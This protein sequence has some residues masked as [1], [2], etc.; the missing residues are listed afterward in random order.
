MIVFDDFRWLSRTSPWMDPP[1]KSAPCAN[2]LKPSHYGGHPIS[3]TMTPTASCYSFTKESL[4]LAKD[5]VNALE[6]PVGSVEMYPNCNFLATPC[7][8][9]WVIERLV[10]RILSNQT[11]PT[12]SCRH[13]LHRFLLSCSS[14]PKL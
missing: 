3:P 4:R 11:I 10:T 12:R 5:S 13:P 9:L 1:R 8:Y 7:L 2:L 6:C 14:I